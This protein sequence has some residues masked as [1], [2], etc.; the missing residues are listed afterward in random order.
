MRIRIQFQI[1]GF[2]DQKLNN[3][4]SWNFFYFFYQKL[5]FTY[6]QASLKY[7]QATEEAFNRQKRTSSTS[8]HENSL[9]LSIFCRSFLAS[10]IR[11]RIRILNADPDPQP[12]PVS[13][14]AVACVLCCCS[15]CLLW[16]VFAAL[17]VYIIPV[18]LLHV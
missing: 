1:Q 8:K 9:L 5:Q 14:V 16:L 10:W 7:A 6:P 4:Y 12:W 11:I 3:I 17:C 18:L 15:L 13:A 2:D